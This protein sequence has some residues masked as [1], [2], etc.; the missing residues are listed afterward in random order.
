MEAIIKISEIKPATTWL[1]DEGCVFFKTQ[2][3]WEWFK[4]RN[5]I[6]LAESGALILGK[7]RA[8]DKVSANVSQVVL[9][10]L[11]RN[12]IESAKRLEQKVFPLQ[13]LKVE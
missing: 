7:G 10:I 8:T 12:S 11:K 9:G 2:S 3:S 4:R 13:N 1:Q 5:A 6:E